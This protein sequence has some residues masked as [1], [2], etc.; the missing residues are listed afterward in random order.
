MQI[1]TTAEDCVETIIY[2]LSLLN[3]RQGFL[4]SKY[5]YGHLNLSGWSI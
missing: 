4:G 1:S 5:G 3:Y 2:K